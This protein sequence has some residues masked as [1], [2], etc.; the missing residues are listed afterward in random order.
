MFVRMAAISKSWP[1]TATTIWKPS[2]NSR[3]EYVE[4][5]EKK[6]L[7]ELEETYLGAGHGSLP[8]YKNIFLYVAKR[9]GRACQH[10]YT[11]LQRRP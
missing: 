3:W 9:H 7:R 4:S 11:V 1:S 10:M 6:A 5:L 8:Q 2:G